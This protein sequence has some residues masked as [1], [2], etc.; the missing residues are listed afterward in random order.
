MIVVATGDF[1]VYH[2]VVDELRARDATFTTVEPGADL[3]ERTAVVI[4]APGD[5]PSGGPERV[6]ADPDEPRTAVEEALS[7]L[8]EA[9][10]RTIVGVDP[11][12][13][14]GIAVLSGETV[15]TAMQVPLAD[16]PG[17]IEAA[18]EDAPD[19]LV[20]V[21]DGARLT[22]ARL[23]EAVDY[24]VELVDE[25]ATTPALG[26]G[27]RGMEDVLAAVNI[28]RREGERVDD[29]DVEPTPGEL[30]RIKT[31]SRERSDGEVT[32]S[33]T[34]ARRVAAG[35]LTLDEAIDAHRR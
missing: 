24:P 8:R 26:T 23:I 25:T 18:V 1:A 6:V 15:V 34:L 19:P 21:G 7:R 10:G 30:G 2:E 3:P 28:A 11:G 13:N 4:A 35:D 31:R 9:D 32:I 29:R 20:R 12:D 17:A 16:A 5:P 27:A 22:G 14:P 33:E